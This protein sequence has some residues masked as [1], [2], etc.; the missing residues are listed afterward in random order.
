LTS[1]L[2]MKLDLSFLKLV[3]SEVHRK[4]QPLIGTSEAELF[5]GVGAGGDK[6]RYIDMVA[7]NTVFSMLEANSLSC[8]V[9]SEERGVTRL[10]QDASYVYLIVDSLDGTSNALRGVPFFATSLALSEEPRLSSVHAG[11]V[12]DL[13]HERYFWAEKGK[14]AKQD[15]EVLK[16]SET[17]EVEDAFIGLDLSLQREQTLKERLA[18]LVSRTRHVRHFGANALEIC[19]VASGK[20]D[21]FI[22]IDRGLRVTDMAAAY[23]ILREAGGLI[24]DEKGNTLDAPTTNPAERVPFVAAANSQIMQ[25]IMTALNLHL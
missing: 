6:T 5:M 16:T 7:E 2:G 23:L 17:G 13:C 24:H 10:G 19:Y 4:I 1:E 9:I 21:A 11:L 12:L 14:G 25:K 8:T 22:N 15:G 3:A 20:L 18:G